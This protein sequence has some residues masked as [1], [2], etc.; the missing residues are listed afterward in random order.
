MI[1]GIDD[2]K[3]A[4]T[5]KKTLKPALPQ[6]ILTFLI[7]LLFIASFTEAHAKG[8]YHVVVIVFKQLGSN[9]G[10]N[11][12][13][14][15]D[16]PSFSSTWQSKNV[17]LNTYASKMRNSG[18]YQIL[19]HTAWGQKSASYN[20]SAAKTLTSNGVSGFIKVFATQLLIADIKLNFEGHTLSERRRLKLNEVHYFDNNGFGVLMRASRI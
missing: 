13:T 2:T 6:R 3:S 16:V 14:F 19:T 7:F 10:N 11:P 12:P 4:M 15:T 8:N 1:S 20:K 5:H 17:Y 18:K 9:P